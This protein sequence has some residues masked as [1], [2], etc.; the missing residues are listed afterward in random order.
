MDGKSTPRVV[1]V[2]TD[3]GAWLQREPG[4]APGSDHLDRPQ[5]FHTF[6]A[7]FISRSP[8]PD[9]LPLIVAAGA[10]HAYFGHGDEWEPLAPGHPE[11]FVIGDLATLKDEKRC[12]LAGVAPVAMQEGKATAHSIG[13][14]LSGEPPKNF[15]VSIKVAWPPLDAR[16]P[17]RSL[18]RFISPAAPP[19]WPGCSSTFSSSSASAIV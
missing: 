18:G 11:L 3:F 6:P 19:S 4:R 1:I 16:L 15:I 14:E 10:S 7:T 13:R 5:N 17:S 9:S 2:G 8:L 12:L